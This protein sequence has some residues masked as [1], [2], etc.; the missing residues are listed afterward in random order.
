MAHIYVQI[1][2]LYLPHCKL[3]IS[4]F[5]PI[6]NRVQHIFSDATYIFVFY[7][8]VTF[9]VPKTR[10]RGQK[11]LCGFV[12]NLCEF[13]HNLSSSKITSYNTFTTL[14]LGLRLSASNKICTTCLSNKPLIDLFRQLLT[15]RHQGCFAIYDVLFT[16]LTYGSFYNSPTKYTMKYMNFFHIF[17]LLVIDFNKSQH[18][19]RDLQKKK[20][21]AETELERAIFTL[22]SL[23]CEMERHRLTDNTAGLKCR[24]QVTGQA[25]GQVTGHRPQVRS[26]VRSHVTHKNNRTLDK[27]VLH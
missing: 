5:Q 27:T 25:T 13:I 4:N 6:Y 7:T 20:M 1:Y 8:F 17:V 26:Q 23:L 14:L 24:S 22:P 10:H 21:A 2:N 9:G 19:L 15:C 18:F 11:Y 3:Y 16:S 12:Y